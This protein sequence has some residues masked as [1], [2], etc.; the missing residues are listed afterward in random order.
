MEYRTIKKT[1]QKGSVIGMGASSI[2]ES[3]HEEMVSAIRHA[4]D[5]GINY[6]D[7]AAGSAKAYA[8]YGRLLKKSRF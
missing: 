1:G 4:I 8:A 2:A 5:H 7:L 3:S 6:F